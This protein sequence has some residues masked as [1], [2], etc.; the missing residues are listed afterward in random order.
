MRK[1][2]YALA[3]ILFA[4]SG[5]AGADPVD[6]LRAKLAPPAR[7]ADHEPR[8][9]VEKRVHTFQHYNRETKEPFW[10]I[11]DGDRTVAVMPLEGFHSGTIY[12]QD[13]R[14][15]QAPRK[16]AMPT[17]RWH[18]DTAVGSELRTNNFIPGAFGATDASYGWTVDG[19]RL[20]LVRAFQ[21]ETKFN[22]WAHRTKKPVQVDATNTIVLKVDPVLGYVVDATYDIRTD[23]PPGRYEFSSAATSGRYGL[24]PG[25]ATCQRIAIVPPEG[26]LVGYAT[27][28]GATKQHGGNMRCADGGFVAFL[29]EDSGWSP[30]WTIEGGEARLTVCGAHTDHDFV[31]AW[32]KDEAGALAK[33]WVVRMRMRAL[34]PELTN[35]V[36]KEMNLLHK[37]ETKLM[38]R[39]GVVE[40][41]EAQ[42]LP[43]DRR[44]R[45]MIWGGELVE[46]E[47]HSGSKSLRF[48]GACGHGDPQLVLE[49][50]ARYRLEGWLKVEGPEGSE[51]HLVGRYYE[52]TPHN[53]ER[54]GEPLRSERVKAGAGWTHVSVEFV[55][56]AWG[57]FI[58]VKFVA[59]E[60]ATAWLDDFRFG[61]VEGDGPP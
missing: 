14:P 26:G 4:A 7:F 60:G 61:L 25:D 5:L 49:P 11:L 56:P 32:P 53:P 51:A 23:P 39:L 59:S 3:L 1:M 30:A 41:F 9:K 38:I 35:H 48:T 52:W 45:G 55:T 37:G 29:D 42:P 12:V 22:R 43:I 2:A 40:D 28:H 21:G 27:N 31:L 46:D 54:I 58:D 10:H 24:W 16:V 17:E 15:G 13:F 8:W 20:V 44:W 47:A 50:S 6:D 33:H 57:P 34:P 36:W 19:A 18:I